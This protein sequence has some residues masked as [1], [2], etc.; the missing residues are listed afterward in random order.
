MLSFDA[1]GRT[2]ADLPIVAKDAVGNA[3]EWTSNFAGKEK[4]LQDSKTRSALVTR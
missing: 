4:K 2:S 3:A 1:K